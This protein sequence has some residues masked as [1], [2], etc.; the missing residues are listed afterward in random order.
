MDE[1][2]QPSSGRESKKRTE[3][4]SG[5]FT[6]TIELFNEK[7]RISGE[8]GGSARY[9][10]MDGSLERHAVTTRQLLYKYLVAVPTVSRSDGGAM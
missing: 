6:Y 7:V 1:T 10:A 8:A 5:A 9:V 3:I 2:R 4:S